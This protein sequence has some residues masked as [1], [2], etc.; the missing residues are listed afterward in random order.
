MASLNIARENG[1][2][3]D[4]I[5]KKTSCNES[6]G[7]GVRKSRWPFHLIGRWQQWI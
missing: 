6:R 3:E 7:K 4:E 2:E 1:E 5:I